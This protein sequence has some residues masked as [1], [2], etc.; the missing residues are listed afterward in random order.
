MSAFSRRKGDDA[1]ASSLS[2]RLNMLS[3]QDDDEEGVGAEHDVLDTPSVE[4]KKW[5]D[6]PETPGAASRSKRGKGTSSNGKGVTL[7]LRD[8]EKVNYF[9]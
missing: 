1:A 7:T 9:Q 6:A 4:K 2:S 3:H 8:Q 5:G